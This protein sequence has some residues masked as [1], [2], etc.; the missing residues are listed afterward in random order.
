MSDGELERRG[1]LLAVLAGSKLRNMW[2]A[3]DDPGWT[4]GDSIEDSAFVLGFVLSWRHY[5]HTEAQTSSSSLTLKM[6]CMTRESLEDTIISCVACVLRFV[7]FRALTPGSQATGVIRQP[8]TPCLPR[9]DRL[10]SRFTEYDFNQMR[11]L[12]H[13]EPHSSDQAF[14]TCL[15]IPACAAHRKLAATFSVGGSRTALKH[16]LF[17]VILEANAPDGASAPQGNSRL[18]P[19]EIVHATSS[20]PSVQD[21]LS[22]SGIIFRIEAGL[23]VLASLLRKCNVPVPTASEEWLGGPWK[24]F[25]LM[26]CSRQTRPAP[27]RKHGLSPS[28]DVPD[29][30]DTGTEDRDPD[31]DDNP[32]ASPPCELSAEAEEVQSVF[33]TLIQRSGKWPQQQDPCISSCKVIC[34]DKCHE[35]DQALW[36]MVSTTTCPSRSSGG[37]YPSC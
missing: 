35:A 5:V 6:N 2:L 26:R 22:D 30:P 32:D 19:L 10:S 9:G 3:E 21:W 25:N 15:F 17:R 28:T 34:G 31:P 24:S 33:G 11:C 1:T 18:F 36:V 23:C 4:S 37:D 29:E 13:I 7:A 8:A 14:K 12:A 27:K 16:A 20:P